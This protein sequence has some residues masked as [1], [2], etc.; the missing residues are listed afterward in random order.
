[1]AAVLPQHPVDTDQ[2]PMP[3]RDEWLDY[4]RAQGG[5]GVPALYYLERVGPEEPIDVEHLAEIGRVWDEY[6]ETLG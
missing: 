6:R 2:W 5:F 4:A 3:N 1:V